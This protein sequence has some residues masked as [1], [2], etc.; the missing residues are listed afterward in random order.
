MG[1]LT[2]LAGAMV[3]TVVGV[4]LAALLSANNRK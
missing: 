4:F 2:F 1:V 3:G